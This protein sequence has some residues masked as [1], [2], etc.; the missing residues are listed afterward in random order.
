MANEFSA[1]SAQLPDGP[2]DVTCTDVYADQK[3]V[4]Q[5]KPYPLARIRTKS[6]LLLHSEGLEL[7]FVLRNDSKAA[8]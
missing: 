8:L 7:A 4:E 6:L 3:S 2:M 5:T 1:A